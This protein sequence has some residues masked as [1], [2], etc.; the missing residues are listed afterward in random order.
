MAEG[1]DASEKT[2]EPTQK[3]MDDAREKGQVASSR[4]VNHWIMFLAAAIFLLGLAPGVAADIS[5][6]VTGYFEFA[7]EIEVTSAGLG[8]LLSTLASDIALAI[9]P[10]AAIFILAAL[11][12]GFAQNGILFSPESIKPTLDKISPLAG[13]KRL[14]SMKS[15]A[16]FAK[17]VLK[18]II[19]G[20]VAYAVVSPDLAT[21]ETLPG[22]AAG[23]LIERIRQLAGLLL[24]AVLSVMTVIAAADFLY[25]R[26]EHNKKLRMSR[27]DM[28]EEYK[29]TEGDPIVKQRLRQIRADRSRKRMIA[30]VPNADVVITNPTHFSVALQYDQGS[31]GAPKVVAKGADTAAKRIREVAKENGVPIVENPPLARALYASVEIDDEVPEDH[32]RAVAEVINYVW[33]LKGRR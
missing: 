3:K 24:I 1:E 18:L 12:A 27:Q 21:V 8:P 11:F 4:E 10:V 16:E 15:L 31:M 25:Q 22:M 33:K 20:S 17:G 5:D 7:H 26:W 13:I 32:F 30:D 29:Q 9:A 2:E 19:V 14:F 28:K 23:D 6:A